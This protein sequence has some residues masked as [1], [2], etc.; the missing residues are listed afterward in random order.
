MIPS[1]IRSHQTK[2]IHA[3]G[4]FVARRKAPRVAT[5]RATC[6]LAEKRI[7]SP[8]LLVRVDR[9]DWISRLD[10]FFSPPSEFYL[11]APT[12]RAQ[13]QTDTS[14]SCRAS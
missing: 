11:I 6:S 12:K 10:V 1:I 4:E 3:L 13:Q 8:P 14:K 2:W 5:E 9:E 7:K